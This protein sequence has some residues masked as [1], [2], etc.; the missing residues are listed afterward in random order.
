MRVGNVALLLCLAALGAAAGGCAVADTGA[1]VRLQDEVV[2]LKKEVASIKASAPAAAAVAAPAGSV[3]AGELASLQKS[4]A[5]LSA[6]SDRIRGEL[7]AATTRADETKVQTQKDIAN[8][9]DKAGEQAQAIQEVKGKIARVDEIDRRV[10]A[11]EGKVEKLSAA[12]PAPAGA[13]AQVSQEWKSPEEMYDHAL[14]L[15][16][17]GE[18]RKG[19][20]ILVAFAA[21][22]PDH[23][24][25]PNVHYWKGE[26][27]YVEKDY[28]SAI[29]S[30]QDVVDKYPNV[31]KAPDA[32][33]KQGLSFLALKDVKNARILFELLQSKYPKSSSAEMARKKLAEIK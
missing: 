27:F 17:G 1:F 12:S 7:L 32:M 23:R 4:V 19:R 29:L 28:E 16:K 20:E 33:F 10:A 8:L 5:D 2:S 30:F 18:T 15:I 3:N 9:N 14:G 21:S 24:L 26:S 13:P 11:L 25:M 31:E 22:Y 6:E